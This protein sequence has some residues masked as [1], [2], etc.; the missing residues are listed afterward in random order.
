MLPRDPLAGEPLA[1]DDPAFAVAVEVAVVEEQLAASIEGPRIAFDRSHVEALRV[2][3]AS[4]EQFREYAATLF[5]PPLVERLMDD[6]SSYGP[7]SG[8]EGAG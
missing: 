8:D 2:S 6:L 4:R 7:W 3:G 1:L 5:P